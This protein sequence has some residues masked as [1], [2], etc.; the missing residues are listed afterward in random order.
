MQPVR[1]IERYGVFEE[2]FSG[3]G[4][5]ANAYAEVEATVVFSRPDGG[6]W[7][8]P[9][10]WD[11]G[12]TWKARISPDAVGVWRYAVRSSDAALDGVAGSFDCVPSSLHGSIV[13]MERYP[14][15]FQY[16][17]GTPFWFF[18]DTGW[19]SFADDVEKNL[20][21]ET[22]L[23]YFDVR[24][25]Q[26]FNYIH[27]A[28]TGSAGSFFEDEQNV[29]Y[30]Y[31][32]ANERLNPEFFQEADYRLTYMNAKGMTAGLLLPWATEW[33]RF[34]SDEAGLRFARY[35][36]AGYSAYNVVFI[37]AGEWDTLGTDKDK[38]ARFQAIGHE[39]MRH[40]PHNRMRAISAFRVVEEF[41]TQPWMS[42]GDYQ[43]LYRAP[44]G[45]EATAA[46]RDS[47]R[48]YL[49]MPKVHGRPVVNSEYAYYLR[50]MGDDH[51]Y[52]KVPIK[53]VDKPHSHTRA[54]FRR[55]SWV[56]AMAGGYFVTGFG[57]TFYGGWRDLGPFDVNAPKNDVAEEDLMHIRE[58]F[59][60]LKWWKLQV[61]DSL[62]KAKEG[63]CYCLVEL[64]RTYVVYGEG[65]TAIELNPDGDPSATYAVRRFDPRTGI[66]MELPDYAGSGP[67]ELSV[68]DAQDCVFLVTAR[69]VL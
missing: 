54:S 59:T 21:R 61:M 8:I 52:H 39:M 55:A 4:D 63:F 6:T 56:L 28:L 38:K 18:G 33:D 31:D 11:G 12:K 34:A 5:Y 17:D 20:N 67:I 2:S 22:V 66:Y 47:L 51:S 48:N 14:L 23:H 42:F 40:D 57:T 30:E 27:I 58:F 3:T 10:F 41:A 29:M 36:V 15:H 69:P 50:E 37:I 68:P 25:S 62:V 26:G 64:G 13:P 44:H 35:V 24:A 49:L 46:E 43:Q 7:T 19:R 60:S 9:L 45:R 1:K 32:Y 16:Q 53:G 65:C